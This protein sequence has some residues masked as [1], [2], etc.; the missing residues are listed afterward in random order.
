MEFDTLYDDDDDCDVNY[1]IDVG[2]D[3]HADDDCIMTIMMLMQIMQIMMKMIINDAMMTIILPTLD[4][5]TLVP[6][7][8]RTISLVCL[9]TLTGCLPW[10]L[11]PWYRV[12][13]G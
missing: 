8:R 9:S 3:D 12:R 4:P 11:S 7:A 5:P 13:G 6:C 1:N 10:I 2:T